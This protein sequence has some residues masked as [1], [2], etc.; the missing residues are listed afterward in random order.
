MRR[1][2]GAVRARSTRVTGRLAGVG[3]GILGVL[4]LPA[5]ATAHNMGAVY[6]SPLPLAVYLAGAA[7]TV[8][9][10]FLF[11]LARDM[12]AAPTQ[13]GRI[14]RVPGPFRL[15]L[16]AAGL[17]GWAWIVV[18]GILGGT[19]EASVATLF[20][21]VYGWVGVAMLSA[22]LAPVW[23]CIADYLRWAS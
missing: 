20:L 6:Q 17:V 14:V 8:A 2:E 12:R 16:R 18:Q 22:L 21:W 15:L 23:E 13:P 7:T 9:L 3:L 10:S 1:I 11:V 5:A 19:S 4:A